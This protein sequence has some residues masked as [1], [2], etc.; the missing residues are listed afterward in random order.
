MNKIGLDK[1]T[2]ELKITNTPPKS[3]GLCIK[4]V[5]GKPEGFCRG[6]EIF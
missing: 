6:H 1:G 5:G 3:K 4:Y 2:E